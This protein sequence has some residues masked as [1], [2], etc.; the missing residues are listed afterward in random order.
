MW[1]WSRASGQRVVTTR[2][3]MLKAE[4]F[5]DRLGAADND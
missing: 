3:Y 1:A 4:L 5:K 2:S